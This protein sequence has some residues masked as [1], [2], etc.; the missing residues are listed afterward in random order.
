M[1]VSIKYFILFFF[2]L[3][4][5]PLKNDI[6]LIQSFNPFLTNQSPINP[7]HSQ[8]IGSGRRIRQLTTP[9]RPVPADKCGQHGGRGRQ[10]LHRQLRQ[11]CGR[12][13]E[14]GPTFGRDTQAAGWGTAGWKERKG[15]GCCPIFH[16]CHSQPVCPWRCLSSKQYKSR[17]CVVIISFNPKN[18][19]NIFIFFSVNYCSKKWKRKG[20]YKIVFAFFVW[21]K[22]HEWKK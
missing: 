7:K 20:Q 10:Q 15:T 14:K 11:S 21:F 13:W 6:T 4:P 16:L 22:M 19:Q 5:S 2:N 17:K 12:V 9:V 18:L 3:F 8:L 1:C